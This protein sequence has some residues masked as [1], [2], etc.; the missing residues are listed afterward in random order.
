M[1]HMYLLKHRSEIVKKKKKVRN[2]TV[3]NNFSEIGPSDSEVN[4]D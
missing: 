3:Y 4:E 1:C 2:Q